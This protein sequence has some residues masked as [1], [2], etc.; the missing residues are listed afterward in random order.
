MVS[1]AY[2]E[3][4]RT[5]VGG[6][7]VN[8]PDHE[9]W[10][11]GLMSAGLDTVAV[12]VY[13]KQG[14]WD[15]DNLWWSEEEGSVE[16]EI[17]RAKARGL[18]VALIL[19]VA[20]DHAFER[21]RFLW[22]G[23]IMPQT[24]AQ[25]DEWFRRYGRFV[26]RWATFAEEEGVDLLGVGSEMSA[27]A[28]TLP[29]R[30]LPSLEE[31]WTNPE[32]VARE[33]ERVLTNARALGA[34][35]PIPQAADGTRF[36]T[37][38]LYLDR[39]TAAHRRWAR[40]VAYLER[41]RSIH[42]INER[43]ARLDRAWRELIERTRELYAGELTF[44]ANF[45]QYEQVGFWDA[46]DL[47]GINAY[48]PLREE[49][50]ADAVGAAARGTLAAGWRRV[51]SEID[52]FRGRSG[53]LGHD[54]LFTELGYVRRE[55][56]SF[57]PWSSDGFAVVP[58]GKG[59][60]LLFWRAQVEEPSERVAALDALADVRDEGAADYLRGAL[61][62]KLSTLPGHREIEPFAVILGEEGDAP[63]A[64]ALARLR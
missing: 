32:K 5:M 48:F 38:D 21:N 33:N 24:D 10:F 15:S 52:L 40:Q 8:E 35:V 11:D 29:T 63:A 3:R 1:S 39:Y 56:C 42:A 64:R 30:G 13:A 58:D 57:R 50:S 47:I 43:R 4:G 9:V 20:L 49:W 53:L 23:M 7:Q 17:R 28:S 54:V 27:L 14:D 45:D 44:A 51:L 22:H 16:A 2:P 34:P 31:Y 26:S 12:T 41:E 19:R 61:Y 62:W 59:E 36:E 6:I 55:N 25:L 18:R 37:L 46:L 60:R